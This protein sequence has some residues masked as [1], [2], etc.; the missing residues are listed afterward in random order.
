M[1]LTTVMMFLSLNSTDVDSN[2][3]DDFNA[4]VLDESYGNVS[5]SSTYNEVVRLLQVSI[6][7]ILIVFGT[8]GSAVSFY[9]MRRGSL[10]EVS[11]CFHMAILAIADAR[12]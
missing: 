8:Y 7:P 9:I 11:T 1:E 10:R 2:S 5:Q 3:S 12:E 4:L 6:N